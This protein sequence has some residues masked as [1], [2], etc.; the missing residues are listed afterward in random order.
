VW[1]ELIQALS[2]GVPEG[3]TGATSMVGDPCVSASDCNYP[4]ALC[5]TGSGYVGG[6]CTSKCTST[7]PSE[8]AFCADFTAGGFCLAVCNPTDPAS[9]RAGYAC[10]LVDAFGVDAGGAADVCTPQ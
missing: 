8:D 10:T 9:C 6:M 4:S 3:P 1:Q 7:C 5:A 2:Y